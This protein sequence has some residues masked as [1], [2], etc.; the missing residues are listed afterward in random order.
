MQ[1]VMVTASACTLSACMTVGTKFDINKVDELKPGIASIADAQ[2][3]LGPP[4]SASSQVNGSQ[5]LQ[6]QYSQGTV[7]GGSGA[8]AA[9]LF[10]ATGIMIRVAHRFQTQ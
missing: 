4:T 8:H 9:I 3:L 1:M 7:V 5:V 2:K 10:D 6:W